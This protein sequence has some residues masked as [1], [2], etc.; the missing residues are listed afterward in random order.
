MLSERKPV[1]PLPPT[2]YIND[3]SQ[4]YDFE[5]EDNEASEESDTDIT[6]AAELANELAVV[7]IV[8]KI[9]QIVTPYF[10]V[11]V[12]LYIY[13]TSAFL[14]TILLAIGII[15]LLKIKQKNVNNFLTLLKQ[16]L[17]AMKTP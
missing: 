8:E 13:N 9:S 7:T 17:L 5:S 2:T 15:S 12:A 11:I 3:F 16:S 14:G 6:A 4:S 1:K 10:I